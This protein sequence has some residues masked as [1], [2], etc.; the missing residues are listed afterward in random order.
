MQNA[1]KKYNSNLFS[2]ENIKK[3]VL[4]QYTLQN[5]QIEQIK[6]KD[7]D[8][9]RAVFKITTDNESYCLKKVYF[10]KE[11]LFFVYSVIEWF[12]RNNINVPRIIPTSNRGRFAEY[13]NMYFILTAW[14][15]GE[16]CNYELEEN[17]ISAAENLASMHNVSKGFYPIEGS[18]KRE[19]FDNLN[20]SLCKHFNQILVCSNNA[21]KYGDK[22]SKTYLAHFEINQLLAKT[23]VDVSSTIELSNLSKALCHLDYVNKNILFDSQ[24]KIWIIDF[25]N[26]KMDYCVHDIAYFL[27]RILKRNTTNWDMKLTIECIN[28]YEKIHPLSQDDYKYI[29]SYLVFPQKYWKISRDYYNNIHKCNETS[30]IILLNSYVKNEESMLSFAYD[31]GKYIENKFNISII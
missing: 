26:S 6:F 4:S 1:A 22:F 16:K 20:V 31:F 5:A 11:V 14:I 21:F 29:F 9:Q 7:T 15:I 17:I 18:I 13:E 19:E 25:D 27:R 30:F 23:A 3:Y 24:K 10:S 8:K 2:E 28:S 12:Y